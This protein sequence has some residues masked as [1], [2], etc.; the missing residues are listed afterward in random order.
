[1]RRG[2]WSFLWKKSIKTFW[3]IQFTSYNQIIQLSSVYGA[4]DP[5]HGFLVFQ[6]SSWWSWSFSYCLDF[7]PWW[8][9]IFGLL[10]NNDPF[11]GAFMSW[12]V[13][14]GSNRCWAVFTHFREPVTTGSHSLGPCVKIV[15]IL[16]FLKNRGLMK[17]VQGIRI[18]SRKKNPVFKLGS[19]QQ[20]EN[21]RFSW[22]VFTSRISKPK[23]LKKKKLYYFLGQNNRP[24]IYFQQ[25][26]Y[27]Q[28]HLFEKLF[29]IVPTHLL[30]VHLSQ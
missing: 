10:P 11:H 17:T 29:Q 2:W 21:N 18:F 6:Y 1:V 22:P 14:G 27:P 16:T 25:F 26:I 3:N 8:S 15:S 20:F 5:L 13:V 23:K 30:D 28:F 12:F 19:S 7:P 4:C 24:W 9:C